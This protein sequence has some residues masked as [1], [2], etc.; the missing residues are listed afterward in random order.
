MK[1]LE[2]RKIYEKYPGDVNSFA[3]STLASAARDNFGGHHVSSR[4]DKEQL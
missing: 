1:K 4:G 3:Q 2:P